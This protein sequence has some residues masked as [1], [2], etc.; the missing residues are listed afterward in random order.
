MTPYQQYSGNYEKR[1]YKLRLKNGK[2]YK[3]CWPNAG[4]FHSEC[5]THIIGR[6][7]ESISPTHTTF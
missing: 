5:G 3:C 7:V 4:N 6:E 1:W 2:E